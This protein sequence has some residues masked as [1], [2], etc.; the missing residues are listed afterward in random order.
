MSVVGGVFL[1]WIYGGG[2]SNVLR[3][4]EVPCSSPVPICFPGELGFDNYL[5]YNSERKRRVAGYITLASERRN[6]MC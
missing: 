4:A 3:A 1:E 5:T 2:K 6:T